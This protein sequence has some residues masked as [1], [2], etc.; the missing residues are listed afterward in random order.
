MLPLLR[1]LI[2][3]C[4]TLEAKAILR[5]YKPHIVAVTGSVGKTST[6]D[7][8]YAVL[9]TAFFVRKSDKSFN[10]EIGIPLTILGCPNAWNNPFGW[11]R[12]LL[13]GLLLI[14]LPN[15]YP[16]WL[17]LEVGADRPG[18]IEKIARWISPEVVVVTR[19]PSVPAHVEFFKNPEAVVQEK[20]YILKT[21]KPGGVAI[22][23]DDDEAVARLMPPSHATRLRFG[24]THGADFL[25]GN[26]EVLYREGR[27]SGIGFRIDYKGSSSPVQV[28][29]VVGRQHLYPFL[30]AAAVGVSCG[31]TLVSAAEALSKHTP[32]PGRMKI[33]S[34]KHGSTLIDDTYNSSPIAAT[35]ALQTLRNIETAGRKIAILGDMLE[36]GSFS[37]EEHQRIGEQ[38]A[39]SATHLWTVG[40]RAEVMGESAYEAG[41]T[42]RNIKHFSDSREAGITLA[43]IITTDDVVLVKGSQSMRMERVVER[44]MAH[45]EEKEKLLVRQETEWK[46]R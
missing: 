46:R 40:L 21:L 18:D 8:V 44:G 32:P 25:G 11:L 39:S 3:F 33:I 43:K 4:I 16:S 12:N 34:G 26:E 17:V 15:H 1:V 10:S 13:E 35:E 9:S 31:L 29:G 24:F 42:K 28:E 22:M 27:P 7:A 23:S 37:K 6:K 30:A 20:S 36:L 19:I 5:K 45:P 41:L 14:L 2:V 38:A